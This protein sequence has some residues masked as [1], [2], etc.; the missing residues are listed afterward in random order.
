MITAEVKTSSSA[1]KQIQAKRPPFFSKEGG[2]SF[3]S[4]SNEVPTSF[5]SPATV[6]P[7]LTVGEP[8]DKYEVEADAMADKVV[9]KL[10][11]NEVASEEPR[12]EVV[13]E[14]QQEEGTLQAKCNECE[15]EEAVQKKEEETQEI[16][17]EA[18]E[19]QEKPI[20]E[21]NAEEVVQPKAEGAT[22]PEVFTSEAVTPA[23]LV[24]MPTVQA[25][26]DEC[27]KEEVEEGETEELQRKESM[28]TVGTP[29][30]EE[31]P[32]VQLRSLEME[33]TAYPIMFKKMPNV[34]LSGSSAGA[35][36]SRERI[37]H[38]AQ[39]MV[40][41]IEAKKDD[42]SGG[43]IGAEHLLEI[44]HLAAKDA[45][46]DE[47]IQNVRYVDEF[48]HWCG[49]FSVY[50]IKKAGI[51]LG[52]WEVGMGVSRFGTL[53]PTDNPQPGDIGY[54]TEFQHHCII[55]AVNGDMID[56]ID[57][58]SGNF[59]EVKER[60]RPRSQFH[61]FFTAFGGAQSTVQKKEETSSSTATNNA[62][63]E[64]QLS[65]TAGKGTRM[66]GRTR[67]QMEGGIGADFSGVNI[68]T[69]SKAVQMS[70]DLNAQAFTHGNDIYFNEGKYRPDTASGKH[71]LAHELT[72]T[73]QQGASAG[74]AKKEMPDVQR[75]CPPDCQ[76]TLTETLYIRVYFGDETLDYDLAVDQ[77]TLD[78]FSNTDN[79][80]SIFE[81][82]IEQVFSPEEGPIHETAEFLRST[83]IKSLIERDARAWARVGGVIEMPLL[84][85]RIS[86]RIRSITENVILYKL[87]EYLEN[88]TNYDPAAID[89]N[90]V[91]PALQAR[92]PWEPENLM[93]AS[94]FD[95]YQLVLSIMLSEVS[96]NDP[97]AGAISPDLDEFEGIVY[98]D[99]V[100]RTLT[101]DDF[102]EETLQV[103]SE[104]F[105][106]HWIPQIEAIQYVPENFNIED[107]RPENSAEEIEAE[108]ELL[109]ADF[110]EYDVPGLMISYLLDEWAVSGLSPEQW[111]EA[112]DLENYKEGLLNHLVDKFMEFSLSDPDML[113]ALRFA[114]I[115]EGRFRSLVLYHTLAKGREM[116][117][118]TLADE[119]TNTPIDELDTDIA[120]IAN[121]PYDYFTIATEIARATYNLLDS[122]V[123]GSAITKEIIDFGRN[124]LNTLAYPAEMAGVFMLPQLF[125]TYSEFSDLIEE[126]E[127]RARE[128]IRESVNVEFEDIAEVIENVA[129][130]ANEFIE[131]EW[132]EMLKTIAKEKLKRNRDEMQGM[133]DNWDIAN[134]EFAI[135][136]R[137]GAE[138]YQ[139]IANNLE[140]DNYESIELNGEIVRKS[141]VSK[142]RDAA[143]FMEDEAAIRLDPDGAEERKEELLEAIELYDSVKEDINDGDFDPLDYAGEV[144]DEARARLGIS[145]FPEGTLTLQ[146]LRGEVTAENNPFL[147]R[148]IVAWHWKESSERAFEELLL[149]AGMVSL[150]V[151]SMLVPGVGGILLKAIDLAVSIGMG[152][153]DVVDAQE[154]LDMARMDTRQ[155]IRRVTVEQAENALMWAWIGLGVSIVLEVGE[156]ALARR[157]KV[158]G[159]G[160]VELPPAT[161]RWENNLNP[162]TRRLFRDNPGLRRFYSE[163][164]PAVRRLLTQCSSPCIPTR[165]RPS[166]SDL[167]RLE[168]LINRF[169]ELQSHK[170]LR[171]YLNHPLR[172]RNLTPAIDTIESVSDVADLERRLNRAIAVDNVVEPGATA[173][174]V[175]GRWEYSRPGGTKIWEYEVSNHGTLSGTRGTQNFFQS[176]HGIQDTWAKRIPGYRRNDCPAILLRD[177]KTGSPHQR[178][179]A[180]QASRTRRAGRATRTYADERQLMIADMQAADV[181]TVH[182]QRI[183]ND[184]DTYFGQ[185]YRQIE[186]TDP[187]SLVK[188]FGSWTP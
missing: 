12:E 104:K 156:V 105:L 172:R 158:V 144:Y 45:W 19:I 171:E 132:L 57:G 94:D 101:V 22:A 10:S 88:N 51:D 85:A 116:Y 181:P 117:N 174:L 16:V 77:E 70:K 114:A 160:G 64:D 25:K 81:E 151:A 32:N 152:V 62:S 170:G 43:R 120:N 186:T 47:V 140:E 166:A 9:Q 108:R 141:D 30:E 54:F 99:F 173:R 119:L 113:Y 185:L 109:L 65:A 163:M 50:A 137:A 80:W 55:K 1:N 42:G 83:S 162:L 112:L 18:P 4:K 40:G 165:P 177:S 129:D 69:D 67:N 52:F 135:R 5:F 6:Q 180:R 60:T 92:L 48:P 23:S 182:A 7:K 20:F 56:S 136:L 176:H 84:E 148:T 31:D 35:T 115:E 125:S 97:V 146:V 79:A 46:S 44:F 13:P 34:Q 128:A 139:D 24:P 71:L 39:K 130:N 188:Y 143:T 167:G 178:I 66:D 134:Y 168:T 2:D 14:A 28:G 145:E 49:I 63:L 93:Q 150:S 90:V 138:E 107:F 149:V 36:G 98:S 155:D 72:H 124:I 37:V 121:N 118:D 122:V 91:I 159:P 76:N 58:N 96:G 100:L 123:P 11:N 33:R 179:T 27:E 53:Q 59:S 169:P 147:A 131:N 95:L 153:K 15:Q 41:K 106:F 89:W 161:R 102:T 8:N 73:V 154:V 75:A 86:A 142:L 133:Y 61:A 38:E 17:D 126:Q 29:E 175:G 103:H 74:I 187:G 87:E 3:F 26:C 78:F 110:I 82:H 21:S 184:S 164:N 111:L 68:H 157:L 127:R 183:I